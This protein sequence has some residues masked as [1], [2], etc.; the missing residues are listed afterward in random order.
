LGDHISRERYRTTLNG[1]EEERLAWPFDK[2]PRPE[3]R[4]NSLHT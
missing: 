4:P 2:R 3:E 1:V